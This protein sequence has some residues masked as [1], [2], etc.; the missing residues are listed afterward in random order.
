MMYA[1]L[2]F[3]ASYKDVNEDLELN[4]SN[5]SNVEDPLLII[6]TRKWSYT[7]GDEAPGPDFG[8]LGLSEAAHIFV[9]DKYDL[10]IY[11]RE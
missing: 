3:Y 6:G 10:F 2:D 4:L 9:H 8:F 5:D 7:Y 11:I 1:N